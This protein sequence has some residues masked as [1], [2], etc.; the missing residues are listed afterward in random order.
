MLACVAFLKWRE[1]EGILWGVIS[2]VLVLLSG[3]AK[4]PGSF[5]ALI[6]ILFTFGLGSKEDAQSE[7]K[8]RLLL[9][10][11]IGLCAI[12]FV[13]AWSGLVLTKLGNFTELGHHWLTQAR[14]MGEYVSRVFVPVALSSDHH[15][16]WTIAWS[17][18]EALAKLVVIFGSAVLI[19]ER[20][21]RGRRWLAAL[22]GLC[23]FHLLL[24]FA[25]TLDEPMVEYRTYPS[26][27]WFG[28]LLA[29]GIREF[30]DFRFANLRWLA[31]PV[32]AVLVL[33]FAALSWSRS[34]VWRNEQNL[35]KDVLYHYPLNL[36]AMGI[37]FKDLVMRGHP[38]PVVM[39]ENM[40]D[41]VQ[42]EIRT[43]NSKGKRAYSERRMHLDYASCQYYIIRAYLMLEDYENGLAK[44]QALVDDFISGRRYGSEDSLFTAYLSLL[45][46]QELSGQPGGAPETWKA[47][48]VMLEDPDRLP[49][50]LRSEVVPENGAKR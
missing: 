19:L 11:G 22:L 15:V 43:Y 7:P 10:G 25:Y 1:S 26:M 3:M 28:L 4:E 31:R 46:C 5:H 2:F 18:G 35:V 32:L 40:P 41:M 30:T 21:I 23:L 37:Y 38:D 14:V 27:P 16:P 47:A 13:A 48:R 17:D 34:T 42:A 39:G 36:R 50:M 44:A 33:S 6:L 12:A 29:Y 9:I 49:E 20:Y 24:R 8:N 45:L